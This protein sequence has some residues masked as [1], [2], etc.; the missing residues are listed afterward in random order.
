MISKSTLI[1]YGAHSSAFA[2]DAG[3]RNQQSQRE[4]FPTERQRPLPVFEHEEESS[5]PDVHVPTAIG[6]TMDTIHFL[7]DLHDD[8]I[9]EIAEHLPDSTL[10]ALTRA[11]PL[12]L[13]NCTIEWRVCEYI[14][15]NP[16]PCKACRKRT[17][18]ATQLRVHKALTHA[19]PIEQQMRR[20]FSLEKWGKLA[21][22]GECNAT[23]SMMN[24]THRPMNT[25]R[26]QRRTRWT[27]VTTNEQSEE[28]TQRTMKTH[29]NS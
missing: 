8:V 11:F 6:V 4:K 17:S 20:F 14:F 23:W 16:Y 26:T 29:N 2:M 28:T 18:T 22:I 9:E 1:S 13:L 25:R 21:V 19:E 15:T 3:N 27:A 10:H 24:N 12:L 7:Y 5:R